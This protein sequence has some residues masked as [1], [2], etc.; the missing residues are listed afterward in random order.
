MARTGRRRPVEVANPAAKA[1]QLPAAAVQ[2]SLTLSP[3]LSRLTTRPVQTGFG[4]FL[5]DGWNKTKY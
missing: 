2:T 1:A 4:F 3:I 5:S